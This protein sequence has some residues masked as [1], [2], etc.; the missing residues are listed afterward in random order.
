MTDEQLTKLS[1]YHDGELSGAERR[2]IEAWLASDADARAQLESLREMSTLFSREPR[3][4]LAAGDLAMLHD[5]VDARR[6]QVVA[7]R[8]SR[9]FTGAAAAVVVIC[10]SLLMQSLSQSTTPDVSGIGDMIFAA[11]TQQLSSDAAS[12][13]PVESQL[14]SWIVADLSASTEGF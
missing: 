8:I 14:T 3:P 5:Q 6:E 12:E 2:D 7:L 13:T 1:A 10:G 9:W 4:Q 11:Q